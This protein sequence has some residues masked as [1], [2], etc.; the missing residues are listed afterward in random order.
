MVNDIYGDRANKVVEQIKKAGGE[1]LAVVAD[2]TKQEEVEAMVSKALQEW[3]SVDILVNNAGVPVGAS[4]MGTKFVEMPTSEWDRFITLNLYG[5]MYCCHA[6]IQ[7]MIKQ[8][9]GKVVSLIS[10]A[11]RVGEA[12]LAPYSGAKAGVVG[13]SKALAK[14]LGRYCIN[15]NCVAVAA[16]FHEGAIEDLKSVGMTEEQINDI[17]KNMYKT[18]P[19]AK[20]FD[21][22]GLPTD[23]ADA[24]AFLAS[25]RAN[26]ITGQ[27]LSVSGGYT[28]VD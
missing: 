7:H 10:E 1:A 13:F 4:A 16:T 14:E 24:V 21:R 19:L 23:I 27:V 17:Q 28:M 8:K 2:V 22:M 18:Y 25:D 12:R 20:G 11:G 5:T 9:S 6:V 26:W 3:G 15:I